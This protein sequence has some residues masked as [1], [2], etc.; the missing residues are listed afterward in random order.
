M[1]LI[2]SGWRWLCVSTPQLAVFS[3][4]LPLKQDVCNITHYQRFNLVS[5]SIVANKIQGEFLLTFLN[6][7]CKLAVNESQNHLG[8][9]SGLYCVSLIMSR[10]FLSWYEVIFKKKRNF[11]FLLSLFFLPSNEPWAR[12]QFIS[13]W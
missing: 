9:E 6:R 2:T 7:L 4:A 1:H 3:A 5:N 13:R 11:H 10:V 12:F 8:I